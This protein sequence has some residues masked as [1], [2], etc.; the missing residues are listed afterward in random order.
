MNKQDKKIPLSKDELTHVLS[1][2]PTKDDLKKALSDY[3]TKDDLKRELKKELKNY[4]TKDDLKNRLLASQEAL[5][6]EMRYE[7]S[8][9]KEDV[10]TGMSKFTNLVLT[11]IDPLLKEL[12]TRQQD[13]EIATA[14]I[15]N[16]EEQIDNHENRISKLEHS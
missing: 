7:L 5:R 3:P 14:Q 11:A 15:K 12:E 9:F 16:I 4:P 1:N 10:M 13:R 8:I 2:Y 6:T